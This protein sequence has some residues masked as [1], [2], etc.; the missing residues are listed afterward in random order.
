M[1]ARG[2]AI[3][4]R[5]RRRLHGLLQP[6]HRLHQPLLE[7]PKS[8]RG[9]IQPLRGLPQRLMGVYQSLKEANQPLQQAEKQRFSL[10]QSQNGIFQRRQRNLVGRTADEPAR[11]V[12]ADGHRP[13]PTEDAVPTRLGNWVA[14]VATKISL[15]TELRP[16]AGRFQPLLPSSKI[17]ETRRSLSSASGF[18]NS[19]ISKS[20]RFLAP[21]YWH[22]SSI[23]AS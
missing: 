11:E 16:I 20:R 13:R 22:R 18:Q 19:T 21:A 3:I 23:Y 17:S 12:L 5:T 8:F 9:F 10:N 1:T 2:L 7:L 15:R 6:S 14:R 4:T